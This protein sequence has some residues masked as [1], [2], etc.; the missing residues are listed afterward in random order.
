M[1]EFIL[2]P[3]PSD[4]VIEVYTLLGRGPKDAEPEPPAAA[5]SEAEVDAMDHFLV[6]RAYRESPDSMK[7]FLDYLVD[8]PGQKVSSRTVG[9]AIRKTWNQVAGMLGAFGRRWRNRYKQTGG[10]FFDAKWNFEENHMDYR[11]P[12]EAAAIIREARSGS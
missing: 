12:E 1:P 2:V 11:M 5:Q 9:D 3:V 4:R 10:W 8:R 6:A 7:A